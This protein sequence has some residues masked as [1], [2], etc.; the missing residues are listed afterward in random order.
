LTPLQKEQFHLV[1]QN[2]EL[3]LNHWYV[4]ISASTQ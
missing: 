3:Y 1:E 2:G 4:L